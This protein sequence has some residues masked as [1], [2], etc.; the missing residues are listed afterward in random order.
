M[1]FVAAGEACV[2]LGPRSGAAVVESSGA[3]F[4]EDRVRRFY[5]CFAAERSL[6]GSQAR[7]LLR[8]GVTA[9]VVFLVIKR[10]CIG[11]YGR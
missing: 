6:A 3:V 4:Q 2:R 7:Q 1:L 9:D 11:L 8:G 10:V 5:D